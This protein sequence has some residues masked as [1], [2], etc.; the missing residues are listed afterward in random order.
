MLRKWSKEIFL[1]QYAHNIGKG[2]NQQNDHQWM[3]R[4][5]NM[6]YTYAMEYY[7]ATNRNEVPIY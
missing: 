4:F 3:N 5:F 7:T 2:G 1:I 6:R